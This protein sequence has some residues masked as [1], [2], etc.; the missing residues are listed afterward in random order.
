MS[1]E[2][3]YDQQI[4]ELRRRMDELEQ[5]KNMHVRKL[6]GVQRFQELV[7]T[8][9]RDFGLTEHELFVAR[10]DA[11]VE[12]IKAGTKGGGEP[13]LYWQQLR[14]YFATAGTKAARGPKRGAKKEKDPLNNPTLPTGVY[15]NPL[16]GER[17][18]KKRR[19]PKQLDVWVDEFGFTEVRSWLKK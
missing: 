17:I 19:N 18:E 16:T 7:A 15:R 2:K 5:L 13:P 4:A 14:D 9:V 11:I 1:L 12:W 8:L 6:E 3:D 10:A